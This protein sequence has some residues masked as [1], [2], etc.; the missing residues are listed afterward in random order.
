MLTQKGQFFSPPFSATHIMAIR[1]HLHNHPEKWQPMHSFGKRGM[2]SWRT[3]RLAIHYL[4]VLYHTPCSCSAELEHSNFNKAKW[5]FLLTFLK[6]LLKIILPVALFFNYSTVLLLCI[7]KISTG[8]VHQ[9][10]V[11]NHTITHT[12]LQVYASTSFLEH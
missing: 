9:L 12:C 11:S 7:S 1:P 5:V 8:L 10:Q 4:A 2:T 6:L 3:Q